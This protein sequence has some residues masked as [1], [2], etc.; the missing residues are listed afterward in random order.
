MLNFFL[1]AVVALF[2]FSISLLSN[3]RIETNTN[4]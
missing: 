1:H 4:K 3:Y 2:C